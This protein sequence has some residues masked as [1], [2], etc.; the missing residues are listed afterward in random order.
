MIIDTNIYSA[1]DRAEKE[2]VAILSKVSMLYLPIIVI[3]EL[4]FGFING[5]KPGQNNSKLNR[6]IS[7]DNVEILYISL[8]TTKIYGQISAQCRNA[9]WA[10][11]NN[12]LWIASLVVQND[13]PFATYDKDFGVF[14]DIMGQNLIILGN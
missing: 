4:Q 9:G 6:F 2:A 10:L 5:T 7:Q 13:L 3:G 8:D 12:D 1:L 11:S 14:A